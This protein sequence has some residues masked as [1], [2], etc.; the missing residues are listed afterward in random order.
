MLI[1]YRQDSDKGAIVPVVL[2]DSQ[3]SDDRFGTSEI[4]AAVKKNAPKNAKLDSSTE[5]FSVEYSATYS[6][7]G[8]NPGDAWR[9]RFFGTVKNPPA[10]LITLFSPLYF[11][12]SQTEEALTEVVQRIVNPQRTIV[13]AAMVVRGSTELVA[14]QFVI[15]SA[16]HAPVPGSTDTQMTLNGA[17]FDDAVIREGAFVR[18]DKKT[19]LKDQLEKWLSQY[20]LKVRFVTADPAAKP[21]SEILYP[22]Q[23][24]NRTLAKL[25][26]Q[27][28]LTYALRSDNTF[29]FFD[30]RRSGNPKTS[31]EAEGSFLGSAGYMCYNFA[32]SDYTK[33]QFNCEV[34]DVKLFSSMTLYNDMRSAV[35]TGLNKVAEPKSNNTLAKSAV[36]LV[37]T[38]TTDKYNFYVLAYDLV[39]GRLAKHL[40]ITAT[41]N[42]IV[43]QSK[44][45]ALL[46]NQVYIAALGGA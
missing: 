5:V 4:A 38:K 6:H 44:I 14:R 21:V 46:E 26:E 25:C 37:A 10:A 24:V 35:F 19:P 11:V 34:F 29:D 22:V 23:P 9:S 27:N 45:D 7:N 31:G 41:N 33:A 18:F 42:W 20:K 12:S 30:S 8:V 32:L 17:A 28:Q 3:R 1:V 43:S 13:Y 2:I 39:D 40:R 16:P 36:S 15:Y